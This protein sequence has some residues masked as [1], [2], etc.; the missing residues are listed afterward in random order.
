MSKPSIFTI[1]IAVSIL[2]RLEANCPQPVTAP[3]GGT[4]KLRYVSTYAER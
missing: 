2:Q 4:Q 3:Q 1:N